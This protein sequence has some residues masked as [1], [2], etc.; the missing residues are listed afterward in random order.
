MIGGTGLDCLMNNVGDSP[1]DHEFL[2]LANLDGGEIGIICFQKELR[3]VFSEALH[4]KVSIDHRHHDL[5]VS[6]SDGTIH[7]QNIS[8][9]DPCISHGFTLDTHTVGSSL[10]SNQF[11]I[12]INRTFQMVI[13]R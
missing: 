4:G 10:V 2:I 13:G 5:P 7:H 11:L 1:P 9:V 6:G 12:E 8:G 3:S